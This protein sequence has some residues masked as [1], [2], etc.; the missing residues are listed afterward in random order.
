MFGVVTSY[1]QLHGYEHE[2]YNVDVRIPVQVDFIEWYNYYTNN[3]FHRFT[4]VYGLNIN[5]H[6]LFLIKYVFFITDVFG[7]G[8]SRNA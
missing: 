6:L 7:K 1:P 5:F 2:L 8:P 4:L 3:L